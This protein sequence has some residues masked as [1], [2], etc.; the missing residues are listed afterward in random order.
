MLP[1]LQVHC[2]SDCVAILPCISFSCLAFLLCYFV[3][4]FCFTR[5][6]S[7]YRVT[8]CCSILCQLNM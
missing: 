1:D 4:Q 6:A 3:S 8:L 2:L 5:T 7:V